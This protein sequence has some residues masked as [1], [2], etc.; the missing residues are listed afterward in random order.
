MF[1]HF[2]S[3]QGQNLLMNIKDICFVVQKGIIVSFISEGDGR[4]SESCN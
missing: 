2:V 3:R 1:I 4:A